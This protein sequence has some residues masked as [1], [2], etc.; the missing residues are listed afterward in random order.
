MII[1]VIIFCYHFL[2]FLFFTENV[3]H[4]HTNKVASMRNAQIIGWPLLAECAI[5][6]IKILAALGRM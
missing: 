4:F 1:Y 2:P 6:V 5:K 3:A